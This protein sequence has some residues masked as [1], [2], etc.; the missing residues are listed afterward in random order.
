MTKN[1]L[2]DLYIEKM[3]IDVICMILTQ[4]M[5]EDEEV[6]VDILKS[7]LRITDE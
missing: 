7:I 1:E 4:Y 6:T 2:I 3:S 5:I